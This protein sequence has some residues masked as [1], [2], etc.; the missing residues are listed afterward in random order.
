MNT[1]RFNEV[2]KQ[3]I[4]NII[5]RFKLGEKE[6]IQCI[7]KNI[8][9]NNTY[10][11]D[12]FIKNLLSHI[13]EVS[14][15]NIDFFKYNESGILLCDTLEFKEII[16]KLQKGKNTDN[17]FH[18]ICT[19]IMTLYLVLLKDENKIE[20]YVNAN[21]CDYEAYS[22]MISVINSKGSIVE[23]WKANNNDKHEE[24]VEKK[25]E[26][27]KKKEVKGA[28]EEESKKSDGGGMPFPFG[29]IENT[30]IGKLAGELAEKI[31]KDGN[32]EM[33]NITNPS[34]I[35]SMMFSG[36]K[37]NP[38]GNIMSTVCS[39]LDSKIKNGELDQGKLF[40]EAQ[41]LMGSSGMFNP[42]EMMK[43]MAGIP[44]MAGMPGMAGFNKPKDTSQNKK[45]N[46]IKIKRKKKVPK[47]PPKLDSLSNDDSSM[48]KSSNDD[49]MM[50]EA[51]NEVINE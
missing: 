22:Q 23:N 7:D 36:D 19:Y 4:S 8:S 15:C 31:E 44:G 43:N 27:E 12:F 10:Y 26:E 28:K 3:F 1:D 20:K 50:E 18:K 45:E 29:D 17:D 37:N 24:V 47:K 42:E 13:D 5:K 33:P 2:Y 39:E 40:S 14:A 51:F 41:G 34:D 16:I 49:K 21:Y 38:I 11:V 32:V 48:E 35:F 25:K 6:L 46:K 30:Q 9:S